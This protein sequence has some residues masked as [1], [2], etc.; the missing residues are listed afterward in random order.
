M[1]LNNL[2][3]VGYNPTT[4]FIWL[5]HQN[6]FEHYYKV[7]KKSSR[8]DEEIKGFIEDR[9]IKKLRGVKAKEMVWVPISNISVDDSNSPKIT[10]AT[11]MGFSLTFAAASFEAE[12]EQQ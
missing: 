7:V 2:V 1:P 10:F 4:G 6:S 3:E 8:Y 12:A 11:P 5:K 9:Q